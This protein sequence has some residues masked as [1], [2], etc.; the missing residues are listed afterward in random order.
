MILAFQPTKARIADN[1][2]GSY[3]ACQIYDLFFFFLPLSSPF[4]FLLTAARAGME[5]A[6]REGV[7][8]GDKTSDFLDEKDG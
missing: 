3:L 8:K 7:G 1:Q 2:A 4:R 5:Y 6:R